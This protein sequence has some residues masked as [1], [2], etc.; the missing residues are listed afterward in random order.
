MLIRSVIDAVARRRRPL[1]LIATDERNTEPRDELLLAHA[2]A[3]IDDEPLTLEEERGLA[4][5]WRDHHLG[6][7]ISSDEVK[8]RLLT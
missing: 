5:A 7:G 4:E 1:R 6:K 3:P 8:R 2:E